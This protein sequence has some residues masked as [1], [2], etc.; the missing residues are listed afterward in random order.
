MTYLNAVEV[1]L[2][3]IIIA[4]FVFWGVPYL[5][6]EKPRSALQSFDAAKEHHGTSTNHLDAS[7][8][9]EWYNWRERT[10]GG[11]DPFRSTKEHHGTS[12]NHLDASPSLE[13][14]NWHERSREGFGNAAKNS[15]KENYGGPPGLIRGIHQDELG[16]RGWADMPGDYEG[17]SASSVS[18]YAMRSA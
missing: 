11:V 4:A 6:R 9:L 8:S 2:V 17:S 3:I 12:T 5:K 16:F 15:G 18:A 13:W 10:V 7:P 1:L 14:Y